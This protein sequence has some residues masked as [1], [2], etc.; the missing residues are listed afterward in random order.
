[1]SLGG[2][3]GRMRLVID[4]NLDAIS[5]EQATE[6]GRILRYWAGALG[7][8]DLTVPVAHDLMDSTYS[9]VG[10]F[11]ITVA[12]RAERPSTDTS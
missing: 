5:G 3:D 10:T 8:L 6:A 2:H 11:T 7:Q 9:P 12:S 1:M 4:I